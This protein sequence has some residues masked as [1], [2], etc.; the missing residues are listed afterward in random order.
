MHRPTS[1]IT[2]PAKPAPVH[3]LVGL[4]LDIIEIIG[5]KIA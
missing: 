4:H 1:G 2:G 3:Q 5:N